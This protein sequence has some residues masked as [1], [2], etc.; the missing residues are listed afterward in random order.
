M[1]KKNATIASTTPEAPPEDPVTRFETALQELEN[2]VTRLEHGDLPLEETLQQFE[3][4]MA[5]TR[6][7]RQSLES[8]ELRV[9]NLLDAENPADS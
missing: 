6:T 4:G 9:R 1:S 5:L 8:A 2:I 3:R 7:C